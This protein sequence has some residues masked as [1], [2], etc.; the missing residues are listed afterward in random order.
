MKAEQSR[1]RSAFAEQAEMLS[2]VEAEARAAAAESDRLAL[3]LAKLQGVLY[4]TLFPLHP[5][6]VVF[7]AHACPCDVPAGL[8]KPIPEVSHHAIFTHPPY[9][10][11]GSPVAR[12]PAAI[13]ARRAD[14]VRGSHA[15]YNSDLDHDGGGG[16]LRID[17]KMVPLEVAK[18]PAD[19]TELE[20]MLRG[21]GGGGGG[22]GFAAGDHTRRRW[23]V[24]E[25]CRWSWSVFAPRC[26]VCCAD[27]CGAR[28]GVADGD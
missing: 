5:A 10:L 18:I 2:R 26:C 13:H 7:S 19:T 23:K 15:S 21:G 20:Y 12:A 22:G 25:G 16:L 24:R 11:A 9:P 27:F 6:T 8:S 28:A 17:S 4:L 3:E 1:L 14:P